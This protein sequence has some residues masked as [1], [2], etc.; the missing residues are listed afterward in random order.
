VETLDSLVERLLVGMGG[1]EVQF[2]M[3]SQFLRCFGGKGGLG[4]EQLT[5]AFRPQSATS[6]EKIHNY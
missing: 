5:K 3:T 4:A 2:P 1:T 6:F